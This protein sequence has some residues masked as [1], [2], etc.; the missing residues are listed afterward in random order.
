MRQ[1][2]VCLDAPDLVGDNLPDLALDAVVVGINLLLHGVVAVLVGEVDD[3]RYLHVAGGLPS[4]LLVVHDNLGMENLLLDTLVEIVGYRPDEHALREVGNLACRNKAVHLGVDGDGGLVP[5]DSHVLPFLQ[6]LAETLG[7][8]LGG[9]SNYLTC[10][11]IADGI[12]DYSGLLVSVITLQL[13]KILKAEHDGYLVASGGG[14]EVVQPTHVDGGQLVDNHGGFEPFLLVDELG[15]LII[16]RNTVVSGT[17]KVQGERLDI[18]VSSVQYQGNILPVE[19]AVY[20]NE[21]MKGLCIE[22]SLERE[23]A[24][25][26]MANI[27]GGLGTSISFARSAGQQVA[28][29]ITRGLMQGGSQYLAKKFRTVKVHLK[30]GDPLML[31]AK[32]Q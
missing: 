19:L 15:N 27:G 9:F 4:D 21:G 26:A 6:D 16:P 14:N 8:R 20:D 17:G 13:A 28:M 23:A 5:V 7:E 18:T 29:D 1:L 22:T 12:T 3:L 11:Y 31:Y 30:A 25:E 32:Q 2:R 24:K 10:K